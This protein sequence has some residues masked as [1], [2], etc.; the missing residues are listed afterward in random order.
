M[1]R[2]AVV[3]GV[4]RRPGEVD[5][6]D[7]PS[8]RRFLIPGS[9]TSCT[10]LPNGYLGPTGAN[11]EYD[12]AVTIGTDETA[13]SSAGESKSA[14]TRRR[15]MDAAARVLGRRG[16]AG[17]RLSDIAEEAG[18]QAAS[19]YYHFSSREELLEEVVRDGVEGMQRHLEAVL[20]EL[21]SGAT[22]MDRIDAA[23]EAHLTF[24][25]QVSDYTKAAIR[26]TS[27]LPSAMA[28]R[29]M[30]AEAAYATVWRRLLADARSAG[31]LR[32]GIDVRSARMLVLGALNLAPEWWDPEKG[33]LES[34]VQT[35]QLMVRHALGSTGPP[36]LSPIFLP[37]GP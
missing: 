30:A 11:C 13:Q 32:P 35:A 15:V 3:D 21:P 29:Q 9:V 14:R 17:T 27:Q 26:N 23:V 7:A 2:P 12:R 34:V 25:L 31:A 4:G 28:E 8:L 18:L 22:P 16:Y 1:L 36:R 20:A 37:P 33:S 24:C 5:V 6:G 10:R 19:I